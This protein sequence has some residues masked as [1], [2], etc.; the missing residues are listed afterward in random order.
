MTSCVADAI[1]SGRS[2]CEAEGSLARIAE[3]VRTRDSA[4]REFFARPGESPF[5]HK[6]PP[7]LGAYL[8]VLRPLMGHAS[9]ASFAIDAGRYGDGDS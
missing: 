5:V 9:F 2:I 6:L 4:G 3:V 1:A 8:R 7:E